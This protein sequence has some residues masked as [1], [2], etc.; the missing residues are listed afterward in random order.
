MSDMVRRSEIGGV[1]LPFS[2]TGA[3]QQRSASSGRVVSSPSQAREINFKKA[4]TILKDLTFPKGVTQAKYMVST[5]LNELAEFTKADIDNMSSAQ[6]HQLMTQA[7]TTHAALN[8]LLPDRSKDLLKKLERFSGMVEDS[9]SQEIQAS[10]LGFSEGLRMEDLN[11]ELG[12]E[13]GSAPSKSD[14]TEEKSAISE[15]VGEKAVASPPRPT[16]RP[17]SAEFASQIDRSQEMELTALLG[18]VTPKERRLLRAAGQSFKERQLRTEKRTVE[19]MKEKISTTDSQA[20][21]RKIGSFAQTITNIF[22]RSSDLPNAPSQ[23]I[24]SKKDFKELSRIRDLATSST[25]SPEGLRRGQIDMDKLIS[26]NSFRRALEKTPEAA[27]PLADTMNALFNTDDQTERLMLLADSLPKGPAQ[28]KIEGRVAELFF[29]ANARLFCAAEKFSQTDLSS[30]VQRGNTLGSFACSLVLAKGTNEDS[31]KQVE[32]LLRIADRCYEKG[33]MATYFS[34]Y[35]SLTNYAVTKRISDGSDASN[36]LAEASKL[37]AFRGKVRTRQE[38]SKGLVIPSLIV[39]FN[40]YELLQEQIDNAKSLVDTLNNI[41]NVLK[42]PEADRNISEKGVCEAYSKASD[43]LEYVR[44]EVEKKQEEIASYQEKQESIRDRFNDQK[45]VLQKRFPSAQEEKPAALPTAQR[46][47]INQS[48][49]AVSVKAT[50]KALTR[51]KD[52]VSEFFP[53][54]PLKRNIANEEVVKHIVAGFDSE[55]FTTGIAQ[56]RPLA[57]A[58]DKAFEDVEKTLTPD[59]LARLQ[60][61]KKRLRETIAPDIQR[62]FYEQFEPKKR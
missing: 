16:K 46:A 42:M 1:G 62:L 12:K 56:G 8:K 30:L 9:I 28:E 4:L 19:T 45:D 39:D 25:R 52:W 2:Q 21:G 18:K 57:E 5:R 23:D 17:R 15:G 13:F 54:P 32:S 38:D 11:A 31:Q 35:T 34:I 58:T 7:K 60:K 44:V 51:V 41:D 61:G 48:M 59:Q 26:S 24:L 20:S 14:S 55:I 27:Q 29:D 33:D 3:V 37:S 53:S 50:E 6:K 40:S 43:K 22:R 36:K 10:R 47:R 49:E